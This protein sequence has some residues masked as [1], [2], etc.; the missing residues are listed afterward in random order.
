MSKSRALYL[1]CDALSLLV[2]VSDCSALLSWL[3]FSLC[4]ICVLVAVGG[5]ELLFSGCFSFY[6]PFAAVYEFK[7]L[8]NQVCPLNCSKNHSHY[9]EK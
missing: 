8:K 2:V 4:C 5:G 7:I 9:W 3:P 6:L 1:G